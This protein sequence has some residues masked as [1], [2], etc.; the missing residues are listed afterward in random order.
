M[1]KEH[2]TREIILAAMRVHSELGSGL[3]ESAYEACLFHELIKQ[4]FKVERQKPVPIRYDGI[5]IDCGYRVDLLVN[6]EIIIEL[7]AVERVL[8]IHHAQIISYL[9]LAGKEIG[10]LINFH[11]VHLRDGITRKINDLNS[12]G[13]S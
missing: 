11:V 10:L 1:K 13:T 5:L 7:K 6:D 9:K 3:L 8:P 4:G 2:I 12:V